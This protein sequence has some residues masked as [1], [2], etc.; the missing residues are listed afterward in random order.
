MRNVVKLLD[1]VNDINTF[2]E[3]EEFTVIRGNSYSLCFRLFKEKKDCNGESILQR[4]IPTGSSNSVQVQFD[5]LDLE[6]C[7]KRTATKP[8]PSDS[9]I[10]CIPILP[11]DQLMFNGM[12]VTLYEDSKV[13]NFIVETDISTEDTGDRRRFT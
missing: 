12:R 1:N 11:Q 3:V 8:F 7:I 13:T 5:N 2:D 6:F 10:W 9:S 4:Y